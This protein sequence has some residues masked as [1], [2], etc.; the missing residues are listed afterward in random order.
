MI[1]PNKI[2]YTHDDV[3]MVLAIGN[4]DAVLSDPGQAKFKVVLKQDANGEWAISEGVVME[5]AAFPYSY[6]LDKRVIEEAIKMLKAFA[7]KEAA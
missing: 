7:W 3:P 1:K 6:S 2:D 5:K 4:V